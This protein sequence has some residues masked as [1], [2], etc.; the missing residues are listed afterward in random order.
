MDV[1]PCESRLW[2]SRDAF[3]CPLARSGAECESCKLIK[4]H[5]PD[6]TTSSKFNQSQIPRFTYL[7][8]APLISYLSLLSLTWIIEMVID[9]AMRGVGQGPGRRQGCP[10]PLPSRKEQKNRG[11]T[12]RPRTISNTRNQHLQKVA[13]DSNTL[14]QHTAIQSLNGDIDPHEHQIL[15]TKR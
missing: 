12:E 4:R 15:S 7:L 6:P 5:G 9:L 10:I 2:R 3:L 14:R 8:R 11:V 13:D 1:R